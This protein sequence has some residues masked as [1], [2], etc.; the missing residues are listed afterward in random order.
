MTGQSA[1]PLT[2]VIMA[3]GYDD[4][5]SFVP[6]VHIAV[7]LDNLFQRIAA[8]DDRFYFPGLNQLFEEA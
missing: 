7:S 8:I 1:T 5:A 4:I 3:E 6:F 2:F